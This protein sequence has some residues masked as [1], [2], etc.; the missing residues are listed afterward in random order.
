MPS[1]FSNIPSIMTSWYKLKNAIKKWEKKC[2]IIEVENHTFFFIKLDKNIQKSICFK[3]GLFIDAPCMYFC[4]FKNHLIVVWAFLINKPILIQF[5]LLCY[6]KFK[7][8]MSLLD[9][10]VLFPTIQDKWHMGI[11]EVIIS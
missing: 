11:I 5:I 8:L 3:K 7:L 9:I 1:Y 10:W 6:H 2:I 4:V